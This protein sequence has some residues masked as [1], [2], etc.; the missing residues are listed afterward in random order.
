[1]AIYH[2]DFT[3]IKILSQ[4]PEFIWSSH[5][6]VGLKQYLLGNDAIN[7]RASKNNSTLYIPTKDKL[8]HRV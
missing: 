3:V 6:K 7:S 8:Y 4:D 5:T 2:R 1:M